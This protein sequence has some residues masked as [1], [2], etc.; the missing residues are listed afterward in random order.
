MEQ[1]VSASIAPLARRIS[2][3]SASGLLVF[4][5]SMAQNVLI[6]PLLIRQW[7]ATKYGYWIAVA[8]LLSLFASLDT[9]HQT[10]V[11]NKITL[12]YHRNATE[13]SVLLGSYIRVAF[14]TSTA[15]L[16]GCWYLS[17][18]QL[19]ARLMNLKLETLHAERLQWSLCAQVLTW[20]LTGTF[21]GLLVRLY[22]PAGLYA[23]QNL[24]GIGSRL[25]ATSTLLVV[26]AGGGG[27]AAAG[28]GTGVSSAAFNIPLWLELK[29]LFRNLY[30]FWRLGTFRIGFS[31]YISSWSIAG[32]TTLMGLA[33]AASITIVS[34]SL[35]AASVAAF[36]I[37][38]STANV[39]GQGFGILVGPVLPE[40]VRYHSNGDYSKIRSGIQGVLWALNVSV[41]TAIIVSLPFVPGVYALWTGRRIPFDISLYSLLAFS[42]VARMAGSP[43]VGYLSSINR[44]QFQFIAGGS[45]LGVVCLLTIALLKPFG[46]LGAGIAALVADFIAS[47]ALPHWYLRKSNRKLVEGNALQLT[48][49]LL[50][51]GG[52]LSIAAILREAPLW[53]AVGGACLQL[54]AL[55]IQWRLLPTEARDRLRIH[56]LDA[57]NMTLQPF[58]RIWQRTNV[59]EG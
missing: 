16:A 7:G 25:V 30:P 55:H 42:V 53:L 22:A 49:S 41:N 12:A 20:V 38:R 23:R 11:G 33:T 13:V 52:A 8:S 24:W 58:G 18:S 31:N 50:P 3:G 21:M 37:L 28:F 19:L 43:S 2:L 32:S 59:V 45:Y 34:S 48:L 10:Y 36:S 9:A 51:A 47:V 44:L 6:V 46:L 39:F 40:L 5:A 4:V 57:V 15:L 17:N 29:R 26:A 27:V 35:G 14:V 56:V 54:V 1:N